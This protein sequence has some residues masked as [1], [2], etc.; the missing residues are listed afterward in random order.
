MACPVKGCS[1]YGYFATEARG[2]VYGNCVFTNG[3]LAATYKLMFS[4]HWEIVRSFRAARLVEKRKALAVLIL[5]FLAR[6]VP[7]D[8][9]EGCV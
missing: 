8:P 6:D 9:V 3:P 7:S 1:W 4:T 5:R 2:A